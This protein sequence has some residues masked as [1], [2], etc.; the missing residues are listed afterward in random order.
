MKGMGFLLCLD[1]FQFVRTNPVLEK[2]AEKLRPLAFSGQVRL[3]ITSRRVP[4][5]FE[6]PQPCPARG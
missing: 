2:L 5:F 4:R 1:D 6:D 3:L